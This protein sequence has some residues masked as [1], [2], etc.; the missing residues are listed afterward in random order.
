MQIR[1]NHV[2]CNSQPDL[3]V[4][5]VVDDAV[6]AVAVADDVACA[7]VVVDDVVAS[8]VAAIVVLPVVVACTCD[9]ML[10]CGFGSS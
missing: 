2:F 9:I 10:L 8:V 5:V 3:H 7:S 4:R 6:V 1:M